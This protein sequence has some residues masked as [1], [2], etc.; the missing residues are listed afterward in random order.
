MKEVTGIQSNI[1]Y[2][3]RA[4]EKHDI[5]LTLAC[6]GNVAEGLLRQVLPYLIVKK[7]Q[8][9]LALDFQDKTKIPEWRANLE[10]QKECLAKMHELNKRGNQA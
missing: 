2:K 10:W 1:I 8:A 7:Q 6:H 5:G 9:E 3:K 4:S